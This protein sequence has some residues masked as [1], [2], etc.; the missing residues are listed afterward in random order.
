MQRSLTRRE[1]LNHLG[2]CRPPGAW[3][4]STSPSATYLTEDSA[5][6]TQKDE[7]GT[8]PFTAEKR[9]CS[10]V[11]GSPH[12]DIACPANT[13]SAGSESCQRI[14]IVDPPWSIE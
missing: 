12:V 1:V 2:R 14:T 3:K 10:R 4:A 7:K 13:L 8:N 9:T 6:I 11:S 5:T